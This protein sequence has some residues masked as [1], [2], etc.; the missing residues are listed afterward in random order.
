MF[1]NL[2]CS[3]GL[4]N[5]DNLLIFKFRN[6]KFYLKDNFVNK[7]KKLECLQISKFLPFKMIWS[8][9]FEKIILRAKFCTEVWSLLKNGVS[10]GNYKTGAVATCRTTGTNQGA[11]TYQKKWVLKTGCYACT[12]SPNSKFS[13]G[14]GGSWNCNY[15]KPQVKCTAT[16]ANNKKVIFN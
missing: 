5:S 3:I 15:K 1:K 7:L 8:S 10:A 9:S 11:W 16:C 13:L 2:H 12:A 6:C 4:I 14:E